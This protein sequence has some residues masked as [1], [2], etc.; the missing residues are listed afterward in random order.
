MLR[1]CFFDLLERKRLS[2]RSEPM[3]GPW[4]AL[5]PGKC[6]RSSVRSFVRDFWNV[7]SKRPNA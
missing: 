5:R 6:N 2:Y 7:K 1:E 4:I 3:G